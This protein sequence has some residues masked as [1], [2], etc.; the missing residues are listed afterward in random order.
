MPEETHLE[1]IREKLISPEE[2]AAKVVPRCKVM[3]GSSA[4]SSIRVSKQ[5]E[6]SDRNALLHLP[7]RHPRDPSTQWVTHRDIPCP[8]SHAVLKI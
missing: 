6:T 5:C 4:S 3:L 8:R 1:L 2:A 7:P